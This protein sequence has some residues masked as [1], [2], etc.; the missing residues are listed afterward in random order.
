MP[1]K[2]GKFI[3]KISS[4]E[5]ALS[6]VRWVEYLRSMGLSEEE[7]ESLFDTGLDFIPINGIM[8]N[9]R[10]KFDC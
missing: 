5:I 6:K 7:Y 10:S 8:G 3:K 1:M 4:L 2:T 9:L